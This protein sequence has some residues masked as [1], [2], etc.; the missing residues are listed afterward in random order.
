MAK[1]FFDGKST[2]FNDEIGLCRFAGKGGHCLQ[3]SIRNYAQSCDVPE[4]QREK[5]ILPGWGAIR[6]NKTEAR[7]LRDQLNRFLE[8]VSDYDQEETFV[9]H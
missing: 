4:E 5:P 2:L 1:T 3:I 9:A 6:I 7:Q 8:G